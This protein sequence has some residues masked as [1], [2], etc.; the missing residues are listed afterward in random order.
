MAGYNYVAITKIN[1]NTKSIMDEQL[2]ALIYD[3]K[4]SFNIAQRIALARGYVLFGDSDYKKRFN[5][6]TEQSKQYQDAIMKMQHS[7]EIETLMNRSVE[8]RKLVESEVFEE[9]DKGNKEIAL[10]NLKEQVEPLAREIMDEFV[11]ISQTR[12]GNIQAHGKEI[13]S[14]GNS[15]M[16]MGTIISILAVVLGIIVALITARI[17]SG[18]VTKV[19]AR[20]KLIASGDLSRDL[21]ETKSRDEIG[22]LVVATNEMNIRMRDLVDQIQQ[23]SES[24]HSQ[25][26]ELTHSAHE[27]K[28]GSE[29]IALTMNEL[30]SGSESQANNS[31]EISAMMG[32]FTEKVQ[33]ANENGE[34]VKEI[35]KEVL[36]MTNEGSLLMESSTNQMSKID[37]IVQ[38]AVQKVQG[39]DT[40]SQEISKLVVVIK[41]ISEQTNLLALNA[42]IEAARAGEHGKGFSVVADE[43][44]KLAEQVAVSVSDITSIVS[45]IQNETNL[46]TESLLEGY[47]EVKQGTNQIIVTKEKFFSI[48]NSLKEMGNSITNISLNLTEIAG[49]SKKINSSIEEVAAISEESAAGI[50]QTSASTQQITSSMEEVASSSEQLSKLAEELNSLVLQFKI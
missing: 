41:E 28:T 35:S 42:A 19:M 3:E 13:I 32:S 9:Y 49:N 20:M 31:G 17:I 30:A 2:T 40:Q 6:Y 12:E 7:K 46:V 5:E 37:N 36:A 34:H 26:D 50:E 18:P 10:K 45:N 27:V 16:V 29:Q 24:V 11:K 33:E 23:V 39:L 21:L 44:R 48:S 25:S 43:V 38:A 14:L 4:L 22:Q 8:W 1:A 15:T 47:E